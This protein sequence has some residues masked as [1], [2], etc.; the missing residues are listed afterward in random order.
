MAGP[1]F[2]S[3][4]LAV[5]P[6]ILLL[7]AATPLR[8]DSLRLLADLEYTRGDSSTTDKESRAETERQRSLFAQLYRLDFSKELTPTLLLNGGGLFDL[9]TIDTETEINSNTTMKTTDRYRSIQPYAEL[10]L[11]TPLLRGATAF[12]SGEIKESGANPFT[13]RRFTE[14]YSAR[15]NWKPVQL[16]TVDM[17]LSRNLSWNEPLSTDTVNDLFELRSRYAY[18]DFNFDYSHLH[19]DMLQ[20]MTD[21][22]TSSTSDNGAIRYQTS[23]FAD[24]LAVSAGARL[25]RDVTEFSGPADRLAATAAPGST[26]ANLDETSPTS[27]LVTDFADSLAGVDLLAATPS[28]LSF[29]L[30][31][32]VDTR[33]DTLYIN[34]VTA[35]SD[36][37][38]AEA[39]EVDGIDHL[40][41]WSVYVSDDQQSWQ[42]RSLSVARFNAFENRFELRFAGVESRYIKIVTTPLNQ[43]LLHDKEIKIA[44]LSAWESLPPDTDRFRRTNLNTD[45]TATWRMSEATSSGYDLH[46]RKETS[47]PDDRRK[48][49]LTMGTNLRHV[50]NPIF[51]GAGRLAR[52]EIREQ[53]DITDVGYTCSMSLRGRYLDTFNQIL[54]YSYTNDRDRQEGNSTANALLLRSNLDLYQ[55]LSLNLDNGYS[56]LYPTDGGK[57]TTT[58]VRL[59]SNITPNRWLSL[60]LAYGVSWSSQPDSRPSRDQT[61]SLVVSWVPFA[62][63]SMS[64]D[65]SYTDKAGAHQDSTARQIYNINWSPFRDGTLQFSLGYGASRN[66]LDEKTTSLNPALKWQINRNS[67][68]SL[69]YS[70]G[71]RED[72]TE[73]TEFDNATVMLRIFY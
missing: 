10:Q 42:P 43:N 13:T 17:N 72:R 53:G 38:Q 33:L 39:G 18:K 73:I 30:D 44:G 12:R 27:S 55:G 3:K 14:E 15:L 35:T 6:A 70:T 66:T 48:S 63:L 5:A 62:T 24:K 60:T 21:A 54:T 49:Y 67:L 51:S 56:W 11:A 2:F 64:A 7:L 45:L 29:G 25:K 16:P 22:E 19:N 58:Y 34:L 41:A 61:G 52:S 1:F 32:G 68:L 26:F 71:E 8:A 46:Y 40:Y 69:E 57:N 65:L 59:G 20:K 9:E 23:L 36:N 31:F 4:G 50:F 47:Q 37:Q 28:Q